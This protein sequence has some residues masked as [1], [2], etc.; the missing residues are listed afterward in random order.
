MFTLQ[1]GKNITAKDIKDIATELHPYKCYGGNG[2]RGFVASYN[3]EGDFPIIG[4]Q[5]ALCGNINIAK[6]KFYATEHAVVVERYC[7]VDLMWTYYTLTALNLNQYA[8]ATAQPG[9]SVA[10]INDVCIPIPPQK[11]QER[12]SKEMERWFAFIDQIE[13]S[14]AD[15]QTAIK[16]AK[17]KI[18]D[19]A[20]HGKLI[21]QD[22]NDEPAIEL[23]KRITPDFTPCD[24][25]HYAQLPDGWCYATIKEAFIINPKNKADDDIEVGFV[26]MANI[27]D[28]YNNTFKYET[29]RWGK[30]KTGFT[31]FANGDIAVAKISPCL[32]NRKSVVL[33]GLPNGIGAGTTELHVFRSL[34]LDVQYGLNFFKSDYFISQCV[35]SF[36][37]VVGQQR[38]SKNIIENMIIAIPPINEQK[39]IACAVHN[40]F[41]KLD[42]IMESL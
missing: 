31:H 27:T 42:M 34:F 32:E 30:I 39:R 3:R 22:P 24:N 25:G 36:N 7:D 18:L 41:A 6:G 2:V 1:A 15:L 29:K 28:G 21:P 20:I 38:V 16:Q 26:P 8:T 14:K 13:Q 35:G 33:K 12:I 9:L 40:I 11:E 23:L 17:S 4:R 10:V 37:G 5:G 19:L